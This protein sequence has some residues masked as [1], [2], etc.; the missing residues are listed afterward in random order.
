[1]VDTG[2]PL[3]DVEVVG[4]QTAPVPELDEGSSPLSPVT[5]SKVALAVF[6]VSWW[7]SIE[8]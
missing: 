1:V 3:V 5:G 2:P 7:R 6:A 8:L 4:S